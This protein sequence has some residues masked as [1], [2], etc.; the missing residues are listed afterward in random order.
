M[1]KMIIDTDC[2]IDDAIAILIA[3]RSGCDVLGITT[4]SGNVHVNQV[5]ENVL[6][7]L[8]FADRDD[9]EVFK[10][11]TVPLVEPN[12][13]SA[14]IH[15]KNGLGDVELPE[16]LR[17]ASE[18][19]APY[20]IYKLARENPGLT[21]VTLG[22]LTNIAMAINLYPELKKNISKIVA[23]GGAIDR[24]NVTRFAEF[25]FYA[26]PE[27]VEFVLR[28]GIPIELTPWDAVIE[29]PLAESELEASFK[30]GS[31]LG[32][33]IIAMEQV[34]FSFVEKYWGKKVV[35]LA[36]PIAIASFVEPS[37][38]KN[39]LF[40]TIKMELNYNTMRG[41]SVLCEGESVE[42]IT[43]ISK[44]KFLYFISNTF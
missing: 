20:A 37:I 6:R 14:P 7:L 42:I 44:E 38:V 17:G 28:S 27:A 23:M 31:K 41:A 18:I 34:V 43:E 1:K 35:Y 15:G 36:D 12:I 2:G 26:D 24:G 4:V 19:P 11:A 3:L 33:F 32:D 40:S 13:F 29:V 8:H 16:A 10:G 25:N 30:K 21:L 5:T 22:P 9:I 39:R